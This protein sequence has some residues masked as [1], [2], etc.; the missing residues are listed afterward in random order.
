MLYFTIKFPKRTFPMGSKK[1]LLQLGFKNYR[2]TIGKAPC[3]DV[4]LGL[5]TKTTLKECLKRKRY[6]R[7]K[8][9]CQKYPNY[10]DKPLPEFIKYLKGKKDELYVDFLNP[11]GNETFCEFRLCDESVLDKM[12]LYSYC[13]NGKVV[14]I[15][16]CR[17]SFNK[18][19][20]NGYGHI[21]PKNCYL[22]GQSTNCHINN[23]IWTNS[24][25]ISFFILPLKSIPKI[26]SMEKE[27]IK[28][29]DPEWNSL[30]KPK[31]Q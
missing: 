9:K 5:I 19:I 20:N 12:G 1:D 14:Y 13:V 7:L 16:R 8:P 26:E 6:A 28:K 10:M 4:F 3:K 18:R 11:N 2:L 29:F 31:K 22:D 27:L 23:L 24:N 25:K 30:L 17:D 21:S 15:G